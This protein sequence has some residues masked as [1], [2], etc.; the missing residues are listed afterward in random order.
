MKKILVW[1]LAMVVSGL[2]LACQDNSSVPTAIEDVSEEGEGSLQGSVD[3][4]GGVGTQQ[5]CDPYMDPSCGSGG[6]GGGTLPPPGLDLGMSMAQCYVDDPS[7]LTGIDVDSDNIDD[8][9]EWRIASAFAPELQFAT[10][11]LDGSRETFWSAHDKVACTGWYTKTGLDEY[12]QG[13][14]PVIRVAYLLGYHNDMGPFGHKGDSEFLI[15]EAFYESVT[16]RWRFNRVYMSAHYGASGPG[17]GPDSSRWWYSYEVQYP[18][19]DYGY[20]RVWVSRNKHGNYPNDSECDA[21]AWYYTDDCD[22]GG[23]GGRVAVHQDRNIGEKTDQIINA[24]PSPDPQYPGTEYFWS[25]TD[26]AGWWGNGDNIMPYKTVLDYYM[27]SPG[28][29]DTGNIIW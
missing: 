13:Y 18:T 21:G 10:G 16:G 5:Y 3:L 29:W 6:G 28:G 11:E 22:A 7:P 23:G 19:Q 25:G 1:L 12:C 17:P 2:S 20:P 24:A 8:E 15:L 27:S 26:F 9:C 14:A 4:G